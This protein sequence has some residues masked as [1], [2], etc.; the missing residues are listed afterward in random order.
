M[1]RAWELASSSRRSQGPLA[2][3]EVLPKLLVGQTQGEL[4]VA[5]RDWIIEIY[6]PSLPPLIKRA[7]RDQKFVKHLAA[8]VAVFNDELRQ[9]VERIRGL[10]DPD[11][12]RRQLLESLEP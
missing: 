7:Y 3:P 4:W 6:W 9:I 5:E 12:L 8:A 2:Q 10:T 11:Q 1:L